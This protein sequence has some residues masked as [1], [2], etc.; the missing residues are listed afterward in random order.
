MQ[1]WAK[2]PPSNGRYAPGAAS[3]RRFTAAKRRTHGIS[4]PYQ[5]RR[6]DAS[7]IK[8]SGGIT[9]EQ[10][11]LTLFAASVIHTAKGKYTDQ[12]EAGAYEIFTKLTAGELIITDDSTAISD[13]PRRTGWNSSRT[14]KRRL[15]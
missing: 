5:F 11:E 3:T 7:E 12:R 9:E 4:H 13:W 14:T 10:K 1:T 2:P 8:I 15:P 6:P